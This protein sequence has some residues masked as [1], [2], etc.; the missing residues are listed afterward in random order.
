[1]GTSPKGGADPLSLLLKTG[2]DALQLQCLQ[3]GRQKQKQKEITK[4]IGLVFLQKKQ[5]HEEA[6]T[7]KQGTEQSL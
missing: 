2:G 7:G 1:L 6:G 4:N 5:E 3:Q